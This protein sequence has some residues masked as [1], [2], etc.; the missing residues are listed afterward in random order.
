MPANN[1]PIYTRI[2][3]ITTDGTTGMSAAITASAG[4]Y[5]GVS[6]NYKLVHTAG[7]NGS[8]VKSLVFKAIGTNVAAVMRV[9]VNNGSTQGTATNNSFVGEISLPATTASTTSATAE[10]EYPL[11][12]GLNAGF[13]I[14]VG[15]GAAVAAGWTVTAIAGQY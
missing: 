15:L 12:F 3:D 7:S 10:I 4:D 6:A 11:E 2:P 9:F 8:Y 14:Y 13:K 1:I 5:T